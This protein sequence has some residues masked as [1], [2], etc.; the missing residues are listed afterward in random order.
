MKRLTVRNS[1]DESLTRSKL[2]TKK[3]KKIR[4]GRRK[5]ELKMKQ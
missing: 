5:K 3:K 2:K 1:T 4:K